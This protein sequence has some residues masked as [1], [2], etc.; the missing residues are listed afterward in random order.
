MR[1]L[2]LALACLCTLAMAQNV[3]AIAP[4]PAVVEDARPGAAFSMRAAEA[5][6]GTRVGTAR[7]TEPTPPMSATAL[8]W[9][10]LAG[11]TAAGGRR[12]RLPG[13][14]A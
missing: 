8:L 3:L 10:G 9:V 2:A 4:S 1:Q 6:G 7:R 11:L 12:E 13:E 14:A 5:T